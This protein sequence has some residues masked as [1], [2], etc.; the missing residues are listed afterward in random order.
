MRWIYPRE[1]SKKEDAVLV[2]Y[3]LQIKKPSCSNDA[4]AFLIVMGAFFLWG[5][6]C[7]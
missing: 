6:F 7:N 3:R 4:R 1:Q 5:F 2:K